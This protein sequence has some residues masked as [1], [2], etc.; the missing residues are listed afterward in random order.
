MVLGQVFPLEA[1]LW[2]GMT[3]PINHPNYRLRPVK[4][5]TDVKCCQL[6]QTN[7]GDIKRQRGSDGETQSR[8][9]SNPEFPQTHQKAQRPQTLPLAPSPVLSARRAM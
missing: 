3:T 2:M 8:P 5:F 1:R 9:S 7:E 6:L 4:H